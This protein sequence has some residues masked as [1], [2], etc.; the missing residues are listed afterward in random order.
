NLKLIKNTNTIDL[1]AETADEGKTCGDFL[2]SKG[3]SR[4][5]TAKLKRI[6]DGITRNGCLIRTVDTVS[7]GD[8]ISLKA[9]DER[10]TE[11]NG[12]LSAPVVY[13]DG[14]V[15]VF[16]KPASM[17]VHPSA[18]HR[19][20]TLGNFFASL[21]PNL[22]FRPIN[23]LDK[24]TSGLCAV[25]KNP[26]A[27]SLLNG[28]ISKTYFAVTEGTPVPPLSDKHMPG[29]T[30]INWYKSSEGE[31]V[32]DAPIGRAEASV[33]R[34]IVRADGKRSVTRYTILRESGAH[35]LVR[36]VL[37]TGRTHQIRVHFSS[38]GH[39]LAGD[40]FYGGG[41]GLCSRQALHCGEMR[42]FRPSD[43]MLTELFCEIGKD[44]HI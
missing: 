24:D 3:V 29:N 23:R 12:E 30:L 9:E 44:M 18:G 14:D 43:G 32:I 25:A 35:C 10:L 7:R 2:R 22:T 31:Y 37:E 38:V 28:N 8:V 17:P 33:V 6:P 20:D 5:L 42:F 41:L 39:P 40:D 27:A 19:G 4:R 34:R 36:V 26:Y 15:I 16:D 11:P 13:E 21:Y 1:T